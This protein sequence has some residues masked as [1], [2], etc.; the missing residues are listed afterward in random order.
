M[1]G[2][3]IASTVAGLQEDWKVVVEAVVQGDSTD[4][5]VAAGLEM[6]IS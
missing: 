3:A 2:L 6:K 5:L 1:S 4:F